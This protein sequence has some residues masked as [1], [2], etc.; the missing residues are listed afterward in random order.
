[1]SENEDQNRAQPPIDDEVLTP[2]NEKEAIR[3]QRKHFLIFL[4]AGLVMLIVAFFAGRT[5]SGWV[6]DDGAPVPSSKIVEVNV[7]E[8]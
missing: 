8:G 2:L 6:S 7:D 1:M 4:I 5:V 3:R